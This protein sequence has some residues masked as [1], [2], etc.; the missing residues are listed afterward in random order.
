MK[1]IF[2]TTLICLFLFSKHAG[3]QTDTLSLSLAEVV[4]LAQ[5]DAPDALLAET[6]M[7]NRYWFYQSILA[8]F[9]PG[10]NLSGD[11]PDL[12]RSIDLITQPDGTSKFIQRAQ[13]RNGIGM[14]LVQQ[15]AA[16]G[17]TVFA[18]TGL[19]RLDLFQST[20]PDLVSYYSTPFSIGFNQPI[21]GFNDLKWNKRIEPLRYQEATRQ[22]A[23]N[24]EN[25]AYQAVDLFFNVFIAQ[26]NLQASRYDKMN[27]D[28]L[29]GI[30]KG[31]FDVGRIAETELLQIE[32]SAM[33]ANAAVQQSVLD[34]QVGTERLRNFLGIKQSVV[35]TME[36]PTDIP[37]FSVQSDEALTAAK[38]NR[39]DVI[40]FERR[41]AEAE[42]EVA[43]A[44]ANS[45]FQLNLNGAFS[46]SQTSEHFDQAYKDP[47]DNERINLTFQIPIAD[48]GK[49]KARL[50]VAQS[51]REL[52]RMNVEQERVNFDQEIFLKVSQFDLLRKQVELA[53]RAYDV[54]VKREEMTR[55]RYYIGKI[56]VTDLNIAI[57]EKEAARRSY[58]STLRLFWLSHYE[59]RRSTLYD[60]ERKVSLVKTVPG[61]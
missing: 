52:E 61:Y 7:K 36:P 8:D 14:S 18:S 35:F 23:E 26:L 53:L 43:Q 51:N 44:K 40:A 20:G 15:V 46:L 10:I 19:Q 42:Q 33:N 59:L 30:S 25:V 58:M 38:G 21:F 32:L 13:M 31:R 37:S 4:T 34:L 56:D 6:R 1:N 16:T 5:S 24:M 39:S 57:S 28:T 29:Y 41:L 47:L 48:W 50:E 3:A 2:S 11:L 55:N 27:A 22:Y 9:K 49:A 45:G 12:N 60:F 54:S 17:G